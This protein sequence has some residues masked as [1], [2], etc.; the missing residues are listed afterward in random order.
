MLPLQTPDTHPKVTLVSGG[1]RQEGVRTPVQESLRGQV[2]VEGARL[3]HPI[4][5]L[6]DR[7]EL[8]ALHGAQVNA[9]KGGAPTHEE[10]PDL[11]DVPRRSSSPQ[12]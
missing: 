7:T 2:E 1:F 10:V 11:R 4:R 6:D 12:L 5:N 3:L 8:S 9:G